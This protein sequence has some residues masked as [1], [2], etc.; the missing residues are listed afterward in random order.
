VKI[1]CTTTSNPR[2]RAQKLSRETGAIGQF[3]PEFYMEVPDAKLAE[4]ILHFRCREAHY[5]KEYYKIDLQKVI[6]T[7]CI[8]MASFF[9]IEEPAF[10]VRDKTILEKGKEGI[11]SGVEGLK[12]CMKYS[13]KEEKHNL[14]NGISKL[15]NNLTFIHHFENSPHKIQ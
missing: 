11:K 1:G 14:K 4:A 9:E 8:E 12:I 2:D 10:F 13:N 15:E 7:A 5:E 3:I 6:I